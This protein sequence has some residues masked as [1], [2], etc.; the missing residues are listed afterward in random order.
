MCPR[1]GLGG[2]SVGSAAGLHLDSAAAGRSSRASM[3]AAAAHA[4]REA[5]EG[6]YVAMAQAAPALELAQA[7]LARLLAVPAAGLTFVQNAE[8]G[9]GTL[10]RV[11]PLA[12][13]DTVA[14]ARCEW[15]PNLHAFAARGLAITEIPARGDGTVELAALERLLATAPPALVHLTQV[16]SHRGLVQPGRGGRGPVP[17]CGRAALGGRGPGAGARRHRLRRGRH[18]RDQP[19]VAGRPAR[20]GRARHRRTLVG[21][22]PDQRLGPGRQRPSRRRQPGLAARRGRGQ[23]GRLDRPRPGRRRVHRGRAGPVW[24]RL[25][26]AGRQTREALDALPGWAVADA[27]GTASAIVALGAAGGQDISGA[28][29]RLLS[30]HHIVTTACGPARAPREMTE[31]L[32]RISPHVDT[33]PDDLAR[34]RGA[35]QTLT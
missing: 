4:E 23:R 15:G 26:A 16:T 35:L 19:Q 33:T 18:L 24:A 34:L 8:A 31:P 10:L 11:W 14:V 7:A 32:L 3:A 17:R 30:E 20:G 2:G 13:G 6:A 27:P 25:A 12:E 22:A 28:R 21:P 29:A 9:L 5:T 1:P